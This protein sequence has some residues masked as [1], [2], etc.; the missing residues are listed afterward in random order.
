MKLSESVLPVLEAHAVNWARMRSAAMVWLTAAMVTLS[1][2]L[3]GSLLALLLWT[4][5]SWFFEAHSEAA[6]TMGGI[7]RLIDNL[8]RLMFGS[9]DGI[10]STA[11]LPA[12]VGTVVMIFLMTLIVAPLGVIVAIYLR[13][14]ARDTWYTDLV[15]IGVQNLAGVPSI[16]Y[17]VFGLGFF[18]YVVGGR[19]DEIFYAD[20]LPKPTFGTPGLLWASLTLAVLTL[21]VVIVAAEEGL[22][23]LPPSLR[24]GS[25]ALGATRAE[26]IFHVLLPAAAP[27]I[28]T[29]VILAVARAAGEVAPLMLV[30][31]VKYAPTLP[32]NLQSPFIHLEQKFM[33]LGF[34][35]YDLTLHANPGPGRLGL[36]AATSLVLVGVVMSLNLA[37]IV[38]RNRLRDRF[39]NPTDV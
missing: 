33:H 39:A 21:P 31:V 18:V 23:R 37:A 7:G 16:I 34:L 11:M 17:G 29:G 35:V 8:S 5:G 27:S 38:L 6:M 22:A 9:A 13:E 1:L 3:M 14:Y 4:G 12:I 15:R 20:S 26:T 28:L 36:I 32:V 10:G 2:L 25:L 19:I 30:G 24:E